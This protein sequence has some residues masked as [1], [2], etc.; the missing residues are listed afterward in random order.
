[1]ARPLRIEYKNAFYHITSRGNERKI[2]FRDEKDNEK[3]LYYL[4]VMHQR[5]GIIVYAYVLMNNHYHLIIET[6]KPNLYRMMR[7]LNGHYTIYFNKRH[8]R[9]GHLFQGRYKSV[10]I[11]KDHYLLELSRYVHL[12]PVRAGL[13]TKPEHYKYSSMSYYLGE[14]KTPS[15]LNTTWLVEQFGS[16]ARIARIRY[17]KFVYQ[18]IVGL[19]NPLKDVY[20]QSILGGMDFIEMITNR[21]L[22]G[23]DISDQ[24]SGVKKLKFGKDLEDIA[25]AVM[26]CYNI[27]KS[28]LVKRKD[29]SNIAKKIFIYLSR[30]YTDSG[31]KKIRKYLNNTITDAA[32][33]KLYIR[34]QKELGEDGHIEKEIQKIENQ[35]FD[36]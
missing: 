23:K 8:K 29:K 7:D 11:D 4:D 13:V 17:K 36:I 28:D 25:M 9:Y 31:L 14:R 30:K 10:L 6:P 35:L 24:I 18:G 21:F 2:I 20:A 12:N 3:F 33:S 22:K 1:M 27:D 15:W 26:Q 32:I 34:T 16:E 5:Y 19:D